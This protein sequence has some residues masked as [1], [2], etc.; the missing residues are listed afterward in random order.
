MSF[1]RHEEI[2]PCGEENRVER[3]V[4]AKEYA[5]GAI[6]ANHAPAHRND[7]SPTGYSSVGCSPAEP[8]SASPAEPIVNQNLRLGITKN[9]KRQV[10]QKETVST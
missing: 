4:K 2:Y 6:L 10:R 1:L 3:A 9:T 5:E 8:T 7:E